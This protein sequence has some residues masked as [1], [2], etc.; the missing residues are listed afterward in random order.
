M[1]RGVGSNQNVGGQTVNLWP[2]IVWF[3]Y[4]WINQKLGGQMPPVILLQKQ[5]R[6]FKLQLLIRN[7]WVLSKSLE[8]VRKCLLVSGTSGLHIVRTVVWMDLGVNFKIVQNRPTIKAVCTFFFA[9]LAIFWYFWE[10]IK[11]YNFCYFEY[12]FKLKQPFLTR[13]INN[14]GRIL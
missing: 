10:E 6:Y 12:V 11:R 2:T 4:L 3:L 7:I 13:T 14:Y 5:I 8:K 1:L 9:Y